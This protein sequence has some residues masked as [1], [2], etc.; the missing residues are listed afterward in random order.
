[1]GIFLFSE[2]L[3]KSFDILKEERSIFLSRAVSDFICLLF[4]SEMSELE[5]AKHLLKEL[6]NVLVNLAKEDCCRVSSPSASCSL[7]VLEKVPHL[8][9]DCFE[10]ILDV[11]VKL[12]EKGN[13]QSA[14]T[15]TKCLNSLCQW[16]VNYDT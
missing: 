9:D 12:L 16:Y 5:G 2:V 7:R 1:M 8:F 14:M 6:Q 15:A 11:L 4:T 10:E 3:K 13:G